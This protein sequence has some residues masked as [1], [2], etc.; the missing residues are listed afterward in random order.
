MDYNRYEFPGFNLHTIT[1]DSFKTITV[2]ISFKRKIKK[3]EITLE[4]LLADNL[5]YSTKEYNSRR[6]MDIECEELYNFGGSIQNYKS[7]NYFIMTL[8]FKFLNEKYTED[9][10]ENKS[11]DFIRKII[12]EPNVQNGEFNQ[13]IFKVIKNTNRETILSLKENPGRYSVIR[14]HDEMSPL[15]SYSYHTD[16]Y[17][18][19]LEKID[20]KKLYNHYIDVLEND[21]IDIFVVGNVNVDTIKKYFEN[22]F[23]FKKRTKFEKEHFVKNELL[24]HDIKKFNEKM[25]LNQSKLAIGIKLTDLTDF[26]RKYVLNVLTFI[27][28]GSG[29]SKLFKKVREENSL[30]Y[31]INATSSMIYENIVITSGIT[32]E[33]YGKTLELINEV[34]NDIKSGNITDDDVNQAIIT[35]ISGC[36]ECLDSP[37]A[38]IA[39]YLSCEY[40]NNDRLEEKQ[41]NIKKVT[42]EKVI[43]LANKMVL[44]TIFFLEEE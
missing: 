6:K 7:G 41:K 3:E 37:E 36:K 43:S 40:L 20:G 23:P 33:N 26:E 24:R 1:T 35:Y 8:K 42:K 29:D 21:N 25:K 14:L 22:N 13:E 44:D 11:L 17:L 34:I 16:G 4:N 18:E 31:Y 12:F 39:N 5:L 9:G 32:R 15:N 27:L 30:C 10:M 2:H 38:I 28:G 19:D